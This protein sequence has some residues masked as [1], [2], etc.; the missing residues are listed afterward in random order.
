MFK[1]FTSAA[2]AAAVS[3]TMLLGAAAGHAS[4]AGLQQCLKTK[5][6][7]FDGTIVDAAL[8]TPALSTL[9]NLVINA[10][11]VDAL[12][13]PGNLTVFAPT[14]E[15]F[16]AIPGSVLD[17]I[18]SDVDILAAVLTYHV[19]AGKADPRRA[20]RPRKVETLQGQNVFLSFDGTAQV[21]Q[22]NVSCQG[23]RTDNGTVWII[24]SVLLP[25]F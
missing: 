1:K 21:N 12:N 9:V 3:V 14:D 13:A 16:G 25:Q 15:A 4:A 2:L 10:G 7:R 19:I 20:V 5:P 23:V 6:V 17:A 24:D 18:G 8:A 22:S 11:L